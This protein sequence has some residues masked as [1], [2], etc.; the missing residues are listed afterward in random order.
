M[1]NLELKVKLDN[2]DSIIKKLENKANFEGNLKQRDIYFNSKSGRL[3][4]REINNTAFQLIY[5]SRPDVSESKVS[6]YEVVEFDKKTA[7]RLIHILDLSLGTKIVVA[8]KRQLWIYKNTRIHLDSVNDLGNFL[9]LKTVILENKKYYFQNE[10][11]NVIELLD[12]KKLKKIKG[13]YSDLL[14]DR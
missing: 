14:K 12:L 11:D 10:H 7:N 13:S 1:K 8:K 6:H 5:Y 9:E 3:K 4:F 2:F